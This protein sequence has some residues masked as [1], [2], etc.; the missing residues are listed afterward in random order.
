MIPL[1]SRY[2]WNIV[3]VALNHNHSFMHSFIHSFIHL[4]TTIY[5]SY[6]S[7][8]A[9]KFNIHLE[10][11]T[12]IDKNPLIRIVRLSV[13]LKKNRLIIVGHTATWSPNHFDFIHG[14]SWTAK[15]IFQFRPVKLRRVDGSDALVLSGGTWDGL[16]TTC[17]WSCALHGA[18][19]LRCQPLSHY[20]HSSV[21]FKHC[22][23]KK[24]IVPWHVATIRYADACLW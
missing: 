23:D 4:N 19:P 12:D 21:E 22:I 17:E 24:V 18:L 13:W 11:Q 9:H 1:L 7:E 14:I 6:V 2:G 3:S 8:G 15:A 5:T 10:F 20:P 16:P